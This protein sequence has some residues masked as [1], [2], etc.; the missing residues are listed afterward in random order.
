MWTNTFT[1]MIGM[2]QCVPL[3]HVIVICYKLPGW[4]LKYYSPMHVCC[5]QSGTKQTER[6]RLYILLFSHSNY[7]H[8]IWTVLLDSCNTACTGFNGTSSTT[9]IS[10]SITT[11]KSNNHQSVIKAALLYCIG[12]YNLCKNHS[13]GNHQLIWQMHAWN[14][15]ISDKV[16]INILYAKSIDI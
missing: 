3:L 11:K 1:D 13:D 7:T 6:N 9:W 5:K 16:I 2:F 12:N 8:L 10:T 4:F 15:S 14:S